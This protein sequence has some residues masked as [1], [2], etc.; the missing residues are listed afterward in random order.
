MSVGERCPWAQVVTFGCDVTVLEQLRGDWLTAG[1]GL[2]TDENNFWAVNFVAA[3]E[4]LARRRSVEMLE[5]LSGRWLADTLS[6]SG[7]RGPDKGGQLNWQLNK[8][9]RLEIRLTCRRGPRQRVGGRRE[10]R[11]L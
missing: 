2:G 6:D 4:S 11:S 10:R 8:T 5:S 1:I 9:Y 7:S 3:P